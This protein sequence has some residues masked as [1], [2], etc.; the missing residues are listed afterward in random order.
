VEFI[1]NIQVRPPV[2][3]PL[4]KEIVGVANTGDAISVTANNELRQKSKIPFMF[5][6]IIRFLPLK[7]NGKLLAS[8]NSSI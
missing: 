4:V 3:L 7:N 1:E 2:Q 8:A 5:S 6:L